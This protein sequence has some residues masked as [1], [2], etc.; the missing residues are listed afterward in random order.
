MK[1]RKGRLYP[2]LA[3]WCLAGVAGHSLAQTIRGFSLPS[4][5]R[6]LS[7][8]TASGPCDTSTL[9]LAEGRFQI[10]V[11]WQSAT[12]SGSGHPVLLTPNTGYFWFF[13][14]SNVELIV[15]VLDACAD[16]GHEWV[17]AGGLTDVG[18]TMTVIDTQGGT[19]MTYTNPQGTAFLPIQDTGTFGCAAEPG[20]LSGAW[21]GTFDSVDLIDCDPNVPAQATFTQ[22]GSTVDGLL[23]AEARGC[24]TDVRFHGT[25]QA[26]LLEGPLEGGSPYQFLPGSTAH[27]ILSGTTLE[28][29]LTNNSP[30]PYPIP[31]G[32]MHLHR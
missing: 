14:S 15:K 4:S 16:F 9:C 24:G 32:T 11:D 26:D 17:F 21:T 30:S 28:L 12:G 18:V 6:V 25:L 31:G 19:S 27:G 2:I 20:P 8:A 1:A 13:D 22:Q 7:A 23:S 29:T 5:G 10:T 3:A